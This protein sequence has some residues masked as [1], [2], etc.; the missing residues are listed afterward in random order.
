[1]HKDSVLKDD[2]ISLQSLE[3]MI[4]DICVSLSEEFDSA[5]KKSSRLA[6][7]RRYLSDSEQKEHDLAKKLDLARS[8]ESAIRIE[9][10]VKRNNIETLRASSELSSVEEARSILDNAQKGV[11]CL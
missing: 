2:D 4:N 10:E 1:M 7:L 5:E 11:F 9:S 6:A 3:T 8:T